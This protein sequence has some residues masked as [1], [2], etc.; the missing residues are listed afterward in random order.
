MDSQTEDQLVVQKS[1]SG[2]TK[3]R[4]FSLKPAVITYNSPVEND[5]KKRQLLTHIGSAGFTLTSDSI[6]SSSLPVDC[7]GFSLKPSEPL[8]RRTESGLAV[9]SRG[10]PLDSRIILLD[11]RENRDNLTEENRSLDLQPVANLLAMIDREDRRT[12][13]GDGD[14]DD[15]EDTP[16]PDSLRSIKAKAKAR[17]SVDTTKRDSTKKRLTTKKSSKNLN[18][19]V[20]VRGEVVRELS[21]QRLQEYRRRGKERRKMAVIL[22]GRQRL[23]NGNHRCLLRLP[24]HPR[25]P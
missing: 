5:L 7:R 4:G 19:P 10:I 18:S 22:L 24:G 14:G 1:S 17:K 9:D 13:Q 25:Q 15:D 6:D 21:Q 23:I 2:E 3:S 16:P 20:R 8:P 12:G 11:S